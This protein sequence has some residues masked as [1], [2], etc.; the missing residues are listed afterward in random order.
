MSLQAS[1]TVVYYL[2]STQ[3]CILVFGKTANADISSLNQAGA[4]PGIP[5]YARAYTLK[6]IANAPIF[7]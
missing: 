6:Q 3:S 4:Y 7:I 1:F 5:T 2:Y